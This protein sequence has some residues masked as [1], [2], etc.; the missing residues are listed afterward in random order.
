MGM[1][2]TIFALLSVALSSCAT[3]FI[4]ENHTY[5][6]ENLKPFYDS[7]MK[8]VKA[9]GIILS[10]PEIGLSVHPGK[11]ESPLDGYTK[12][13]QKEIIINNILVNSNLGHSYNTHVDSMEVQYVVYH[14]LA[15]YLLNREHLPDSTFTIMTARSSYLLDYM[16]RPAFEKRLNEELF[17]LHR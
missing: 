8:E 13:D 12:Y 15:H 4:D 10:R 3:G 7:F 11:L 14:E 5:C 2:I 6:S 9:R 17:T 16:R 1:K